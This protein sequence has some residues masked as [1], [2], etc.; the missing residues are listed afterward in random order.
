[1]LLKGDAGTAN[2][3]VSAE[4]AGQG[5]ITQQATIS[6]KSLSVFITLLKGVNTMEF[7]AE[8]SAVLEIL[9]KGLP[10]AAEPYKYIGE[11]SGL[12]ER[13]VLE[14]VKDLKDRKIIRN[15]AGI[16][17]G[18]SLGYKLSLVSFKVKEEYIEQAAAVINSHPGVSHNYLRKHKFNIWFTLAEENKETFEK[19][20][21]AIFRKSGADD[22]LVLE[23]EKLFKIGV[24]L[25]LGNSRDKRES[26]SVLSEKGSDRPDS[27][28]SESMKKSI[29]LLQ[30]DLPVENNPFAGLIKKNNSDISVKELIENFGKLLEAGVMRR[31]AAVLRH[32]EAGYTS[33]AMTAWKTG[34]K[35]NPDIFSKN[36]AITHLYLRT[37]YPGKWE[38]PLFAMIHARSDE[39][40]KSIVN[41]LSTESG[42]DDYLV[43]NS[44][45]EFKKTRVQ[46]FSEE[47]KQWKR[48]NYD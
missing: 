39:E 48:E 17:E 43:L 6:R 10:P 42:I 18:K 29:L 14:I 32:R 36:R 8:E 37:I 30:Q 47:F 19:S 28:I 41:D 3:K 13:N 35:F 2:I 5:H 38:Y 46:Y 24:I 11:A 21:A 40:L 20:L 12:D 26:G 31:Y 7:K 4:D 15:I 45:K 1:M 16:F 34:E 22:Y 25:D 23:N 9:Q 27:D 44:L 33:N